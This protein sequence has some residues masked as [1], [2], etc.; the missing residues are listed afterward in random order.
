[1]VKNGAPRG[2]C[3]NP[4]SRGGL[5]SMKSSLIP[6][7]QSRA[8][9]LGRPKLRVLFVVPGDG[10][11]SS[12]IFVR[13]QAEALE[14]E[15]VDARMFFLGSRTSVPK[16]L[17]ERRR[18]LKEL[19]S[20]R[21]AVVHAQFGTVTALF[22][23]LFSLRIPL[24]ITYRGSDLN[25][26]PPS[27]ALRGAMRAHLGRFFSELA[28]LGARRI[29]CVSRELRDRLWWRRGKVS[30]L[31]T[32]VR[33]E[34]FRPMSRSL[35]RRKLGWDEGEKIVLFNAGRDPKVKR[36]D[37]AE[38]AFDQARLIVPSLRLKI[39]DGGVSPDLIPLM[40]NASD[41]LLL[42]S[43]FE[44]SPTVVQEALASNLPVVAVDA[45]DVRERLDGVEE[46]IIAAADPLVLGQALARLVDPPRRSNGRTKIHEFSAQRV[47]RELKDIYEELAAHGASK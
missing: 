10:Q 4:Q 38:R 34:M 42:T 30:V 31:P 28:S 25:P 14:M 36:L 6:N 32:D 24:V 8:P 17:A 1:M 13:R 26:P 7:A 11:G 20:F 35:A 12:M 15:G 16:L 47:A 39:L 2:V 3:R 19:A 29:V 46:S 23:A 5:F 27:Y 45:G 41:C 44:G 33:T 18:F 9:K 21:P 22:A 43:C 40:M 37:L